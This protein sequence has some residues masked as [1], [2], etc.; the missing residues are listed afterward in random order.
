MVPGHSGEDQFTVL[1]PVLQDYGI[2]KQLGA[3]IGNNTS[4][5]GILYRAIQAYLL[6]EEG[7]E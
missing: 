5:N 4:T 3:I 2:T 1:Q 6:R 7:L